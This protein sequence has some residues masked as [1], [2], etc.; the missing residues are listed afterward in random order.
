VNA[1]AAARA[2]LPFWLPFVS[3]L[4]LPLGFGAGWLAARALTP[5]AYRR[6]L[7]ARDAFW[8]E[9]ARLA[10]PARKWTSLALV[11]V[12]A[13][14]GALVAHLGGP[15]SLLGRAAA[16]LLGGAAALAGYALGT[17]PA[18]RHLY[19]PAIG[20][21]GRYLASSVSLLLV[22]AP[23]LVVAVAVAT[24]MPPRFSGHGAGAAALLAFGTVLMLAAAFGG[25]LAA[26]RVL[27]LVCPADERLLRAASTSASRAGIVPPS[28]VVMACH[29]PVAF[30][31]PLRR[32]LVF[33]D[34]TLALLDDAELESVVAHETGHLTESRSVTLQRLSGLL[35]FTLLMAGP[36][37]AGEGGRTAFFAV[38][39]TLLALVAVGAFSRRTAVAMEA[40]AD[41]LA[42]AHSEGS[43]YA[44]ALEKMHEGALVPAVLGKRNATHPDLWD[45]MAAAGAPP[46]W[47]KPAPPAG[48]GAGRFALLFACALVFVGAEVGFAR[49][50]PAISRRSPIGAMAL[51]GGEPWPLSELARSDAA[52][53]RPEDAVALYRAAFA[54]DGRPGHLAN[55]AFV[56]NRSGRCE[57]A[58]A[59]A[60][61]AAGVLERAPG[62]PDPWEAHLVARAADVAAHCRAASAGDDD[63]EDD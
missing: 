3:L 11:A 54:L 46:A 37:L 18:A 50:L 39:F 47:P 32:S 57:T 13:V 36:S 27:G 22:R 19:G 55:A 15:L 30:A 6:V 1:L 56:E 20:G 38:L 44:R 10:W 41:A 45:R 14:L 33:A 43:V 29:V 35:F 48:G 17:W 4:A 12:P 34:S 5:F 8:T 23:H 60:R 58:R 63:P 24:F 49:A 2:L 25:G 40:R 59:L 21:R 51:T 61:E 7:A 28:A 31:I 16:G 26:G 62:R 52:A 9:R 42:A 53:G